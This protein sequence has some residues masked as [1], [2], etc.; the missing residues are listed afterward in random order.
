MVRLPVALLFRPRLALSLVAVPA[1]CVF[2]TGC[3][4]PDPHPC[5]NGNGCVP[6]T[7]PPKTTAPPAP[8]SPTT[9]PPS[10]SPSP[11]AS[12]CSMTYPING[13]QTDLSIDLVD[14]PNWPQ[15]DSDAAQLL[16]DINYALSL[17]ANGT[18]QFYLQALQAVAIQ[19]QGYVQQGVADFITYETPYFSD[20]INHL[21]ASC[22]QSI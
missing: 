14:T 17:P 4:G 9:K 7:A 18:Q 2:L 3:P 19:E 11:S 20:D 13:N 6:P 10:P 22:G 5:G 15:A 8:P 1:L 21:A 16:G 12:V